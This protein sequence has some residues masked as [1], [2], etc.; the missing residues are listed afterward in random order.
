MEQERNARFVHLLQEYEAGDGAKL[1]ELTQLVYKDLRRIAADLLKGEY[2]VGVSMQATMLASDS[3]MRLLGKNAIPVNDLPHFLA[4]AGRTMR[5][6]LIDH[7]R[8]KD[9]AKRP[10][11]GQKVELREDLALTQ[12]ERVEI[13]ALH[14]ALERLAREDPDQAEI[15]EMHYFAGASVPEIAAHL[16]VSERT[17]KRRLDAGRLFLKAELKEN[18]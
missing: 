18:R 14:E 8:A 12:D 13:L 11:S 15:L 10:S 9:A 16:D 1:N 2:R 4:V 17:V 3:V 7:A 6:L 5:Q